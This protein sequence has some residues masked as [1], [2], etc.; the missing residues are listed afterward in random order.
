MKN[1]CNKKNIIYSLLIMLWLGVFS[2]AFAADNINAGQNIGS[3]SCDYNDEVDPPGKLVMCSICKSEGGAW[4]SGSQTCTMPDGTSWIKSPKN[5]RPQLN[6]TGSM[7]T[8]I[9]ERNNSGGACNGVA[10][11]R[12]P[13]GSMKTCTE[14][15]SVVKGNKPPTNNTYKKVKPLLGCV[16]GFKTCKGG[17]RI[18]C[19]SLC[20]PW[21]DTKK[22][23]KFFN[24][25]YKKV[26]PIKSSPKNSSKGRGTIKQ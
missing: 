8:K 14:P 15:C 10:A 16:G 21:G 13:D 11:R 20:G 4:D 23:P 3:G 9:I 2:T 22:I 7:G 18:P 25:T 17:H 1:I 24:N 5:K 6:T 19:A 12:C 26:V